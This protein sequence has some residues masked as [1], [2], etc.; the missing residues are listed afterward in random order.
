MGISLT[1]RKRKVLTIATSII[2]VVLFIFF[3][4][5][6][7]NNYYNNNNNNNQ[8]AN[9]E[10]GLS[11]SLN[12][13]DIAV[14]IPGESNRKP[15]GSKLKSSSDKVKSGSSSGSG[16]GSGSGSA[17]GSNSD[18]DSKVDTKK[19]TNANNLVKGKEGKID[20]SKVREAEIMNSSDNIPLIAGDP[21]SKKA[22]DKTSS[23]DKQIKD[24]SI[25]SIPSLT[26]NKPKS[27]NSSGFKAN[28]IL[29]SNEQ[30]EI[31]DKEILL[32]SS[33]SKN[34]VNYKADLVKED[35]NLKTKSNSRIIDAQNK[36]QKDG[37]SK[38]LG[39]SFNPKNEYNKILSK[40]PVVIFSKSYC[41]FSKK[42]KKLLKT[43]Y[44]ITPEPIII[45]LDDH[46]NGK[47]LQQHIGEV[48]GRFTVPNLIVSGKSRG[49]SDDIAAL[50]END[51][52]IDLF[53][54]WTSGT[55]TIEKLN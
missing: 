21:T 35:D 5:V 8:K 42:L 7:N 24:E 16:S 2:F 19:L 36:A 17:S 51:E 23:Q 11:S 6:N 48:T 53:D 27:S 29:G 12:N 9:S 32:S 31:K 46:E 37:V 15:I 55:A 4:T 33:S 49:G 44:Q 1:L 45:E 54:K 52:L 50:H 3:T 26:N 18:N 22:H 14:Q 34:K 43:E 25:E 38:D 39:S 30:K 41:P 40:S 20:E 47:E 13:D 28:K 10:I